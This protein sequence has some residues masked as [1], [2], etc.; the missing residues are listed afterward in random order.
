MLPTEPESV[1][2]RKI[3]RTKK[4]NK[5]VADRAKELLEA[6]YQLTQKAGSGKKKRRRKSTK[7]RKKRQRSKKKKQSKRR[8][9]RS[10]FK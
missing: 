4:Y 6:E 9:R 3:G 8:R 5:M 2:A 1:K 7:G 10:Y